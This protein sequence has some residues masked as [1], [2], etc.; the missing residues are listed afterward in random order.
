MEET[1]M[2]T[3]KKKEKGYVKNEF[4][5]KKKGTNKG[6]IMHRMVTARRLTAKKGTG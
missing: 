2:C 5:E 1:R 6:K 3:E 4:N